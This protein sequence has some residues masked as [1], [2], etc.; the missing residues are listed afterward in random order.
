MNEFS[1]MELYRRLVNF[2]SESKNCAMGLAQHRSD[3]RWMSISAGLEMMMTNVQKLAGTRAQ[4]HGDALLSLSLAEQKAASQAAKQRFSERV[5][6]AK[7][8]LRKGN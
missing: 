5:N 1:E 4:S 6:Q 3:T 8:D 7:D 2:L